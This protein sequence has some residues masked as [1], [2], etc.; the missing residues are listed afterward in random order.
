[1]EASSRI[2]LEGQLQALRP[3]LLTEHGKSLVELFDEFMQQHDFGLA[4]HVVCDFILDSDSPPVSKS[5]LDQIR[6]L[7]VVM[8]IEDKCVEE[9]QKRTSQ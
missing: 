9:L 1:M 3:L 7:H 8:E 5:V 2:A 4:L 6:K